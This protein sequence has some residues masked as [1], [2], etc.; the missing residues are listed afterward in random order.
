MGAGF[1]SRALAKCKAA[2]ATSTTVTNRS[3]SR[4]QLLYSQ[5]ILITNGSRSTVN[6]AAGLQLLYSQ[7]GLITNGSRSTVNQAVLPLIPLVK[8]LSQFPRP[9]YLDQYSKFL[10]FPSNLQICT[11]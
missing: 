2:T 4:L 3:N 1:G 9:T 8:P 10:G 5:P 11:N 7:P 6:Q